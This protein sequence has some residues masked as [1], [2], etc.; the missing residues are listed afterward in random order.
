[1]KPLQE[2]G[3]PYIEKYLGQPVN[4]G[5]VAYLAQ[6][7]W[8]VFWSSVVEQINLNPLRCVDHNDCGS[9]FQSS[10]DDGLHVPNDD[11]RIHLLKKQK[12][13]AE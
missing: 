7:W 11:N 4:W 3:R 13:L 1:M 10:R 8:T 6:P 2:G 12:E 9:G 5:I